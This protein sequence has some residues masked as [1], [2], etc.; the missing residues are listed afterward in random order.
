MKLRNTWTIGKGL[1]QGIPR[2]N[3]NWTGLLDQ[4]KKCVWLLLVYELFP[5]WII[6]IKMLAAWSVVRGPVLL[7][8][9][10]WLYIQLSHY[11][12]LWYQ[13]S[14]EYLILTTSK[15]LKSMVRVIGGLPVHIYAVWCNATWFGTSLRETWSGTQID[16][17]FKQK[18]NFI[19]F[20]LDLA[21]VATH[22]PQ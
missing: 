3:R 8:S 19:I 2:P 6:L 14:R 15:V 7:M 9:L 10:I 1:E 21:V 13:Y 11:V 22:W 20:S 12:L 16:L 17:F 18:V 5:L 4:L